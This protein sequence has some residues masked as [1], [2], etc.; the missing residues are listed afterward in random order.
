MEAWVPAYAGMARK[1]NSRIVTMFVE[2]NWVTASFAGKTLIYNNSLLMSAA[3]Q[4]VLEHQPYR[5]L[6]HCQS[7]SLVL[8]IRHNLWKR[9]HPYGKAP[10]FLWLENHCEFFES[11]P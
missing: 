1:G 10:F 2:A 7:F 4:S 6:G 8:P 5:V 3:S 11:A 9:W